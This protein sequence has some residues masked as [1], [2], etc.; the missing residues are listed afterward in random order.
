MLL[1]RIFSLPIGMALFAALYTTSI[2]APQLIEMANL[3][4]WG[5]L[6]IIMLAKLVRMRG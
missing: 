4:L 6:P 2:K 5:I 1:L 3:A